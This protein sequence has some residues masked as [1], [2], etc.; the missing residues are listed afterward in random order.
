MEVRWRGLSLHSGSG[1]A[2]AGSCTG[3][4]EERPGMGMEVAASAARCGEMRGREKVR[5]RCPLG[6]LARW[7]VPL[8]DLLVFIGVPYFRVGENEKCFDRLRRAAP[9]PAKVRPTVLKARTSLIKV[10]IGSGASL[11]TRYCYVLFVPVHTA[12][13]MPD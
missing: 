10:C 5:E 2:V 7:M 9:R 12:C 11:F 1:G 6:D 4:W 13:L 3:W 8:V